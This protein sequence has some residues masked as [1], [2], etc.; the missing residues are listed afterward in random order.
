MQICLEIF[1]ILVTGCYEKDVKY[2]TGDTSDG[3]K[4]IFSTLSLFIFIIYLCFHRMSHYCCDHQPVGLLGTSLTA[5]WPAGTQMA[6]M[7]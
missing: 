7:G 6:V 5:T 4:L 1:T 3:K 2:E